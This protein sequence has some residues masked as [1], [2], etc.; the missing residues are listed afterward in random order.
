MFCSTALF[1]QEVQVY[2][3]RLRFAGTGGSSDQV[4]PIRQAADAAE[5]INLLR[6]ETEITKRHFGFV[7]IQQTQNHQRA[8]YERPSG[9]SGTEQTELVD[10]GAFYPGVLAHLRLVVVF[11]D[12]AHAVV[13][14]R[15]ELHAHLALMLFCLPQEPVDAKEDSSDIVTYDKV[16]VAGVAPVGFS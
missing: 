15:A 3:Q 2:L 7:V 1:V 14:G 9:D 5:C 4:H 11:R 10:I 16:D 6:Q 8:I 13:E 12:I